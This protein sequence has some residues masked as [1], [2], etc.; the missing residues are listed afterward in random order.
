[1]LDE[2]KRNN[3]VTTKEDMRRMQVLQNSVMRIISRSRYDTQTTTLLEKTK[4]RSIYQLKC[5]AKLS[6]I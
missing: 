4:Q 3:T 5:I 2:D 1:M 6:E